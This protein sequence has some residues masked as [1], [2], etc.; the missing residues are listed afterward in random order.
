[1]LIVKYL[2]KI[3]KVEK[4]KLSYFITVFL[5]SFS[6]LRELKYHKMQIIRM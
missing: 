5:M 4:P 3:N 6:L 1:M 2:Y